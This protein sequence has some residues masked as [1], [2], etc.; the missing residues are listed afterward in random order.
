MNIT[1]VVKKWILENQDLI[2]SNNF[3]MLYDK[4]SDRTGAYIGEMTQVFL[5]CGIDPLLRDKELEYIPANYLS[6]ASIALKDIKIPKQVKYIEEYAFYLCTGLENILIPGNVQSIDNSAFS[7]C[8]YLETVILEEGV[9]AI[10]DY[11]FSGCSNLENIYLP[12]SL[13]WMGVE[14]FDY[15]DLVKND[16]LEPT[17]YV[18]K[19]SYA[20]EWCA[21]HMRKYDFI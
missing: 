15:L 16:Y 18:T 13:Q 17:F 12:A 10:G 14:P 6:H 20:H 4:L 21:N 11:C 9:K 19:G 2:N 5:S 8:S 1:D 3:Q 7:N